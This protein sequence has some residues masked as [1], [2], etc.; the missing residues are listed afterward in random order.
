MLLATAALVLAIASVNVAGMLLARGTARGKET[1]IRLAMG[2]GRGRLV[3]QLVTESMLLWTLGGMAGVL[4][5]VWITDLLL[6]AELPIPARIEL[7]L[8]VDLRVLGF[9]LLLS[10][11]TAVLF[12]LAPALRATRIDL[13]PAL[14]DA[15]ARGRD[16]SRLRNILVVGQIALS[17]LLLVGAGLFARALQHAWT[18]D[19]GFA[20]D[21]AV[22][23]SFDFSL[24]GYNSGRGE[25]LLREL[26]QR[27]VVAPGIEATTVASAVPLGTVYRFDHV[28]IPG[29]RNTPER[30]AFDVDLNS[31]SPDYFKTM[32]IPLLQGRRFT[33][34]DRSGAAPVAI[35]NETM[36]RR[37]WPAGDAVGAHIRRNDT[38]LEIVGVARD[39]R[40]HGLGKEPNL[41]LY[42]PFAQNPQN[43]LT[44][45]LRTPG[46]ERTALTRL[47]RELRALDPD[48]PLM[49]SAPLREWIGVKLVPQRIAATLT[50]AFGLVGL[51]LAAVGLYGTIAYSVGQRTREI[52][53]RMALGA[54]TG[55]VLRLVLRRAVVLTGI[56][57]ALGLLLSLGLTRFVSGMLVG[58]S[59]T[60]PAT[61][62]GVVLL[63]ASVALLASY[64]PARRAVRVDP[65]IALRSE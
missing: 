26:R 18:L 19:P 3:R 64:L 20:V 46:D 43:P 5:S 59:P 51:L 15:N 42:T 13:V 11:L 36:A 4:V 2:A 22:I 1:A 40:N 45:V 54:Q 6:R 47:R 53:V 17:L 34:A 16:R 33:D 21:G 49:I 30:A 41:Y 38:M 9:A 44:L 25:E 58:V 55:D 10:A 62:A 39:V 65:M 8:G 50:G 7:D 32:R 35:I 23:A 28:E 63:L 60:D 12:G 56:G 48:A 52:G 61:F 29:H 37:F 27:L 31:I 24:N 14:K 57:L